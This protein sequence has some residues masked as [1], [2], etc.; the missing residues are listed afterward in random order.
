MSNFPDLTKDQHIQILKTNP[1]AWNRLR[2]GFPNFAPNLSKAM[3]EGADLSQADLSHCNLI[4]AELNGARLN[5]ALFNGANLVNARLKGCELGKT[6]FRDANLI[7]ANLSG[8][9]LINADMSGATLTDANLSGASLIRANLTGADLTRVNLSEANLVNSNLTD[10]HLD[11]VILDKANLIKANLS[12]LNLKNLSLEGAS[13]NEANL[14]GANLRGADLSWA[15]LS[16][17]TLCG[18][19]LVRA[20]LNRTNLTGADLSEAHFAGASMV[21]A[22]LDKSDLNEA[23]LAG[24]NL[25][26]ASLQNANFSGV[27]FDDTVFGNTNLKNAEQLD[28]C[29]FWGPCVI[30]HR[31]IQKSSP[32][33]RRFLRGCG[34]P[35]SNIDA[36]LSVPIHHEPCYLCFSRYSGKDLEFMNELQD[37]LQAREVRCWLAPYDKRAG[38]KPQ[39]ENE[40]ANRNF[41]RVVVLISDYSMHSEWIKNE[42][43]RARKREAI[44]G[45]RVLYPISL[46]A[47]AE[48]EAWTCVDESSGQD[49]APPLRQYPIPDFSD[50][51]NDLAYF[52][53]FE[54]LLKNLERS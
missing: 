12:G 7:K 29:E 20:Q 2:S 42:I 52:R 37:R 16:W 49:L 46:V 41:E 38:Q 47:P 10:A 25:S 51:K 34:L 8:S 54:L 14:N 4:R 5:G 39:D 22:T 1:G 6:E 17:S 32:L 21:G 28:D 48:F 45:R 31:T 3:L 11:G 36:F 27:K 30:D 13:L 43:L 53:A 15:D 26:G 23:N 40:Q 9:K 33:P 19:S 44:E 35:E 24:V 50:W 18:A